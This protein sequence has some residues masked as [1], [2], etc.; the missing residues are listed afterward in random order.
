MSALSTLTAPP[1]TA[2]PELLATVRAIVAKHGLKH[3]MLMLGASKVSFLAFLAGQEVRA[4]T[5]A[6]IAERARAISLGGDS[7]P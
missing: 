3:A 7:N 1:T 4:G 5:V 2:S 6:L